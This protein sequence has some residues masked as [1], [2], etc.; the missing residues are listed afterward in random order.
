MHAFCDVPLPVP[1]VVNNNLP[2]SARETWRSP[3]LCTLSQLLL[4]SP[5]LKRS[6]CFEMRATADSQKFS[7]FCDIHGQYSDLL[8]LLEYGDLP[9]K[10]HYLF[11][12]NYVDYGIGLLC[13]LLWSDPYRDVKGWGMNDRGVSYTFGAEKVEEF[14]TK[15]DLDLICRSHKKRPPLFYS[16]APGPES[17]SGNNAPSQIMRGAAGARNRES[18]ERVNSLSPPRKGKSM[19]LTPARYVSKQAIP[20]FRFDDKNNYR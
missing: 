10:A 4:A 15:L 5:R 13:D 6:I 18:M 2:Q 9:P 12:G 11:M 7:D 3:S 14:L 8:R 1:C 17:S 20:M 19:P 16:D